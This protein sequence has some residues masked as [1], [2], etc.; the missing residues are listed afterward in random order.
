MFPRIK[1]LLTFCI[2]VVLGLAAA[3]QDTARINKQ[4]QWNLREC[5]QYAIAHNIQINSLRLSRKI[6]EQELML[7]KASRQPNLLASATADA[8]HTNQPGGNIAATSGK[9][10]GTSGD[11]GL[12]SSVTL[13]NG[14]AI[15]NTILQKDAA[16]RSADLSIEQQENDITIQVT[17]AYLAI[18]LDKETIV[19]ATDVLNTSRAQVK[20]EQQRFD[21]GSAAKKD[22]VQ[23]QAQHAADEFALVTA[24]NNERGDLLTLKQLLILPS[25]TGF[26]IGPVDTLKKTG[27]TVSLE[28]AEQEALQQRPEIK[29]AELGIQIAD[30]GIKIAGAG[31]KPVLT[32]GASVGSGYSGGNPDYFT[33]LNNNFYQQIGLTLAI[34]IFTRRTVK[35]QVEEAKINKDQA[36]LGLTNTGIVLSQEV[37]RAYI[38]VKNASGQ[39]N[40][41]KSQYVFNKE[42]YRIASEQLRIGSVNVVDF[43]VVKSQFI[44]AEQALL[45]AK[46]SLL[47]NIEIYNF[48][49][50]IPVN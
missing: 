17:Q 4:L 26:D 28:K 8:M 12:N 25:E 47:L 43:L 31:Y 33:Q 2:T 30:Y 3:A 40:A 20:L 1:Y 24:Q 32:A 14:G 21:V 41:A 42:S 9:G 34:P 38:N 11:Y 7:A 46:Y 13:Y 15:N 6:S 44:Q 10:F 39:Y 50:G 23:L 27:T 36:K 22:L 45:Q 29:N 48:Y 49:R 18:L 35:T 19:Y 37:E 16:L 5:I